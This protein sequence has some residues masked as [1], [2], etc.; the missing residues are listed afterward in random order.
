[1]WGVGC[2][3]WGVG[4]RGLVLRKDFSNR[5]LPTTLRIGD[6]I[7]TLQQHYSNTRAMQAGAAHRISQ[8]PLLTSIP[9]PPPT[10]FLLI[11][12]SSLAA[13]RVPA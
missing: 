10:Y 12:S 3:V 11:C 2:G 5:Y 7:A 8:M 1:V 9:P 13:G 6:T 4:C